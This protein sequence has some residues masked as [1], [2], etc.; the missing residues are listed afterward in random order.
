[1]LIVCGPVRRQHFLLALLTTTVG[2]LVA[3][4]GQYLFNA[5]NWI[6]LL[7]LV[8]AVT[9]VLQTILFLVQLSM[10]GWFGAKATVY[11]CNYCGTQFPTFEEASSHEQLCSYGPGADVPV[12]GSVTVRSL[13]IWLS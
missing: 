2:G 10:F 9:G 5:P 4:C 7:G 3:V 11:A 6:V 1:M 12:G 13:V 8:V